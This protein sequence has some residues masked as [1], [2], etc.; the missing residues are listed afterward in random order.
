M[1]KAHARRYLIEIK[2]A[3]GV[4]VFSSAVYWGDKDR[5]H[6]DRRMTALASSWRATFSSCLVGRVAHTAKD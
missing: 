4:V 1:P 5:R 3:K 2:D 6:V